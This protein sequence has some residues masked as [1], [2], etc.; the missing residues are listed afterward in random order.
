[1]KISHPNFPRSSYVHAAV[2]SRALSW[3][4]NTPELNLLR[5]LFWIALC[6]FCSINS[7]RRTPFLSQKTVT[8]IYLADKAVSYTHL[9]VYKRQRLDCV[10]HHM[11]GRTIRRSI[12]PSP[13]QRAST[14]IIYLIPEDDGYTL[15]AFKI[16]HDYNGPHTSSISTSNIQTKMLL[17]SIF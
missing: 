6:S 16:N 15:M 12:Q 5:R 13:D 1:M 4:N 10:T 17:C 2:C 8:I 7:T 11:A 3:K 9:D 14:V